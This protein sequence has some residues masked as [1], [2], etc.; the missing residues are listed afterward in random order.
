MKLEVGRAWSH[1]LGPVEDFRLCPEGHGKPRKGFKELSLERERSANK[2]DQQTSVEGNHRQLC[3]R[4]G[5]ENMGKAKA[6]F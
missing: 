3:V 6:S 1:L 2:K 5:R 4:P